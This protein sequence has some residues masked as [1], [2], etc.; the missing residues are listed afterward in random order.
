M[1][2]YRDILHMMDPT[3]PAILLDTIVLK[4]ARAS[5][6]IENIVTTHDELYRA[7]IVRDDQIGPETKEVLNYRSA[8]WKGVASL[9]RYTHLLPQP[10]HHQTQANLL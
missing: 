8:M 5:S 1:C 2:K 4:E 7:L 9:S 10:P 6:E 3:V